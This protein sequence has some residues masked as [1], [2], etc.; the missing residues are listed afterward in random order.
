M[1]EDVLHVVL[2]F[3]GT[4]VGFAAAVVAATRDWGRLGREIRDE[5]H[6]L[7]DKPCPICATAPA[8]RPGGEG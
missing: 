1:S 5:H 7:L 2:F 4:I 3:A 6:A 8:E